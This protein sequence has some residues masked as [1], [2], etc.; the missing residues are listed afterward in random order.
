MNT[1]KF[2]LIFKLHDNENHLDALFEAGCDD[3]VPGI[4][5]KGSLALTF[6]REGVNAY[7]AT[8]SALLNVR[9][10][11]PHAMIESATPYLMNLSDLALEFGFTKQNMSKYARGE[12][13]LGSMPSPLV[14]I[15]KVI[16][17][18]ERKI[19]E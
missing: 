19:T 8:K 2:E 13:K 5:L 16:I 9:K 14:N 1:Y 17:Y 4:G 10:A 15:K 18:A 6:S 12:T 11:I 7:E 3:S